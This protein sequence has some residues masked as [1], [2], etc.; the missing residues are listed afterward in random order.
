M[1]VLDLRTARRETT[2]VRGLILSA[3]GS[4]ILSGCIPPSTSQSGNKSQWLRDNGFQDRSDWDSS[5]LHLDRR[6]IPGGAKLTTLVG[7]APEIHVGQPSGQEWGVR[8][9]RPD[10]VRCELPVFLNGTR[11]RRQRTGGEWTLD[12]LVRTADLDGIEVHVGDGGPVLEG[13]DCGALLLWSEDAAMGDT[14]RFLGTIEGTVWGTGVQEVIDVSLE[15]HSLHADGQGDFRF[16]AVLPGLHRLVVRTGKGIVARD[17]VR[18]FAYNTS[19]IG[20][21]VR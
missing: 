10:G 1:G 6:R 16:G 18:V 8:R 12:F 4:L 3:L 9:R 20:I 17:T 19:S 14:P 7:L 15:G 13:V 2:N 21:P 5:I 11:V